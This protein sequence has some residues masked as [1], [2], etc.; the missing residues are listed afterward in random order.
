MTFSMPAMRYYAHAAILALY[1]ACLALA[2][3]YDADA[4]AVAIRY[5]TPM[6]VRPATLIFRCR[7]WHGGC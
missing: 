7:C 1:D 5:A 6:P 4:A 2:L 3:R